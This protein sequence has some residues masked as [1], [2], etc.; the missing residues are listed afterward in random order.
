M[1]VSIKYFSFT[2]IYK[3]NILASRSSYRQPITSASVLETLL[4]PPKMNA[5]PLGSSLSG[6]ISSTSSESLR[7]PEGSYF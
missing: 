6:N 5:E 1:L 2:H 4:E 7:T 3:K